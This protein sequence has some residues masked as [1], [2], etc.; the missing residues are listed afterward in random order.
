MKGFGNMQNL[1]ILRHVNNTFCN[2][3][4]HISVYFHFWHWFPHL[5]QVGGEDE[6][7]SSLNHQL[8]YLYINL[9]SI[10]KYKL[11]LRYYRQVSHL[12]ASQVNEIGNQFPEKSY[13][14]PSSYESEAYIFQI[15][16]IAALTSTIVL[17]Q[18]YTS[19]KEGETCLTLNGFNKVK[20]LCDLLLPLNS[21]CHKGEINGLWKDLI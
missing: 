3:F 16:F 6:I 5:L 13:L 15:L 12:S 8:S 18:N 11:L 20:A 19:A 10:C 17:R 9:F 21:Q 1:G 14:S 4:L 2:W 7:I